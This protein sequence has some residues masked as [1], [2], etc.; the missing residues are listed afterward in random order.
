MQPNLLIYLFDFWEAAAAGRAD[1]LG[2]FDDAQRLCTG[3]L[4]DRGFE[5]FWF[6]LT[7]DNH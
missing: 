7:R 6:R 2:A 3:H 4:I 5:S 1:G